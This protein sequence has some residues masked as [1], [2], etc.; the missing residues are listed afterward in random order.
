MKFIFYILVFATIIS[1]NINNR[2]THI[3]EDL[4]W[5]DSILIDSIGLKLIPELINNIDID[6][7]VDLEPQFKTNSFFDSCLTKNYVGIKNALI[8]EKIVGYNSLKRFQFNNE[9]SLYSRGLVFKKDKLNLRLTK[10]D[11]KE[12]KSIYL[13][14]WKNQSNKS[15]KL[16]RR[17]WNEGNKP[18][19]NSEFVWQ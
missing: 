10:S 2:T 8:V 13:K 15:L 9:Y 3:A 17:E 12:L 1:C 16:I 18:L 7:K 6:L 19:A 4:N 14:W 5:N 11:L